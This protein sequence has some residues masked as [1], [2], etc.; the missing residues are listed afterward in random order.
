M[1]AL[2]LIGTAAVVLVMLLLWL[3]GIKQ[4]NF[5]YVDIGWSINFALLALIYGALSDGDAT[6]RLLICLMYLLWSTRLAVHLAGRIIGEPEEGRYVQLRAEWGTKGNLN[7]KFLAFFQFQALLNVV[8]SLP[9]LFA[10]VNS[11]TGLH[12]LEIVGAG[13]WVVAIGGESLADAQLKRFKQVPANKG[14]VCDVGLW[15]WSRHPN[16]FFEWL[17]WIGYA[18][19]ALASPGGWLTLLLPLLMLHFLINVT[20][21]KPTEEQALRSRGD[22]YRDYQRRVSAF[23]PLPPRQDKGRNV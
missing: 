7:L 20:G 10:A 12:A 2:L 14:R 18:L 4:R 16:Y 23:I 13:V 11:E 22:A 1:L 9:M 5:S 17:I 6:R 3:L 15:G 21:V 19:F 8:L